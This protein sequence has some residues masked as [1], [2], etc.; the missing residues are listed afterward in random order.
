MVKSLESTEITNYSDM[1]TDEMF[2]VE[3]LQVVIIRDASRSIR[4]MTSYVE[5]PTEVA[6]LFD[7]IAYS[8]CKLIILVDY[9]YD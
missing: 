1:R 5:S 2:V 9:E 3:T 6:N 4:P 7:S 8:K